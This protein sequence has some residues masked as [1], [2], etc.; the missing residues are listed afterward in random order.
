[1]QQLALVHKKTALADGS[2]LIGAGSGLLGRR[3]GF[4]LGLDLVLFAFDVCRPAFPFFNF[5]ILSAHKNES[6]LCPL[7]AFV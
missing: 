5:V 7:S 2:S 3:L 6:L 1:M 4:H